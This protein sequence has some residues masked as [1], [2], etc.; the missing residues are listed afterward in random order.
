LFKNLKPYTLA[1]VCPFFSK[2]DLVVF[3]I[4]PS[5]PS[6]QDQKA[7]QP[8]ELD[9]NTVSATAEFLTVSLVT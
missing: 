1:L 9:K 7:K 4:P 6:N 3:F 5:I 8:S 2:A